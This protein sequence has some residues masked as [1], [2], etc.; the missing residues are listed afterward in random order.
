MTRRVDT[1]RLVAP[2][3]SIEPTTER[4]TALE[5]GDA[6][7][8]DRR[9]AEAVE[10]ATGRRD[11]STGARSRRA[12]DADRGRRTGR[13]P[14]PT[15]P[16]SPLEP[17][18]RGPSAG[19]SPTRMRAAGVR[20]AFT[21]PGESFL[22][23]LDALEGAGIRVVATRHE[24][25]AAFM[26]EAH[27]QL[28][29]RPAACLGTRAVGGVQPR[30][31]HPHRPPGLDPDVRARRPGRARVPG[32]RGLPG[33][34]PGRERSAG[35]PSG[36]PSR[37]RRPTCVPASWA[38]RSARRS[39][40]RPGPV[41]PVAAR[42]PARRAAARRRRDRRHSARRGACRPTTR[43]GPSSSSWPAAERP[44][45]LAGGG[46]LRPRTST[47]LI[48][49]AELLQRAG[50]RLLASR[51]RHPERPSAVPRAWPATGRRRRSASGWPRPTRMLVIGC[52]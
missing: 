20:Y 40:G 50:H 28:T 26:A 36:R 12:G 9:P 19:S 51:R 3:E 25:A 14:T 29:G 22:G 46:V 32:P 7:R 52:A 37:D 48:R 45:I 17:P 38:R 6:P 33:D 4:P 42:G 27:G 15:R 24:G 34:R 21:V 47:D 44:V 8:A 1:D 10:P 5:A 43:S 16:R 49:L 41:A 31:R 39:S 2:S 30:D 18:A 35:S 23:L 13:T 11:L